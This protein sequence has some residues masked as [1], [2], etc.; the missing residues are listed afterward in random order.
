MLLFK[1]LKIFLARIADVSLGTL[2]T[3]LCVKGKSFEPFV[4]AFFEVLI[5]YAIA[6]EALNTTGNTI[7]VA[8]SYSLGYATGTYIGSI[9]SKVL[10]KGV[11]GVQIIVKENS[12]KLVK[13]LRKIGYGVSIIELKND[14]EGKN[15]DMLY[16][17]ANNKRL[18]E[19]K[20][21][22][23]KYDKNAFL[24]VNDTKL[25]QNGFIK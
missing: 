15:K 19:L 11:V 12:D 9:L 10:I 8:I 16:I 6:K 7:Y 22:V 1:C 13:Q 2:R 4:I 3:V 25:I 24:V 23:E 20:N 14:Y 21:I 17:Q 18:K 5:W